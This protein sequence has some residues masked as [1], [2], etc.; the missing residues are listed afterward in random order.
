VLR[1]RLASL[2]VPGLLVGHGKPGINPFHGRVR[3]AG[4]SAAGFADAVRGGPGRY[5]QAW[6]DRE[7]E[8]EGRL[9]AALAAPHPLFEGDLHRALAASLPPGAP[10]VFASSMAVRDA[11]W[12]MPR[13]F[14]PLLPFSQRG[15]NGIDGTVS[16]ARGIAAGC[17]RG[18]VLVTGELAFLHD[19]NGL[20]GCADDQHGLFVLVIN[21]GG[22]GIFDFLPVAG[23]EA[24]FERFFATPQ[25]AD[26]RKRAEAHGASYLRIDDVSWLAEA[27]AEWNG[28]GIT[29][30]EA[31]VDRAASVA[32]HRRLLAP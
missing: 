17:G 25:Q 19:G 32:A 11:D 9:A 20:L 4:N 2:D 14:E 6:I 29:V 27:L 3:W 30:A 23:R 26:L 18:A 31:R 13:R 28:E 7:L 21:N 24:A 15:A 16:L 1:Q 5:A 8:A 22:G 12:F 10:L